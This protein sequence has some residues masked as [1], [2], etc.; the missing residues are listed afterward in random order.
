MRNSYIITEINLPLHQI[1]RYT[2]LCCEDESLQHTEI[3]YVIHVS[4]AQRGLTTSRM[5]KTKFRMYKVKYQRIF[6]LLRVDLGIGDLLVTLSL[7]IVSHGS[8]KQLTSQAGA[9]QP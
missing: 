5:S 9:P 3:T 2:L 6:L 7:C 4:Y 1:E 8:L